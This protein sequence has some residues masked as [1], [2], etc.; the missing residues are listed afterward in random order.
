MRYFMLLACPESA[1]AFGVIVSAPTGGTIAPVG[2]A[3]GGGTGKIRATLSAIDLPPITMTADDHLTMAAGAVEESG[4]G[5]HGHT[6]PMRSGVW[7]VRVR[8]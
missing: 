6:G 8:S 4:T 2:P 1:L 3:L 7:P 5:F